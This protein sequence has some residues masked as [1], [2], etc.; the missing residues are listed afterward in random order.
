M[1]NNQHIMVSNFMYPHPD[2]N[3]TDCKCD[4]S[5]ALSTERCIPNGIRRKHPNRDASFGRKTRIS[6]QPR[7]SV[8]IASLNVC[9]KDAGNGMPL[10][11]YKTYISRCLKYTLNINKHF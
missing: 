9:P 3:L 6:Q 5:F 7:Q 1:K 11:C 2:A 4:L 8:R 10:D